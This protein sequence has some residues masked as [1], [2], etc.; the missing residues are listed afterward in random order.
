MINSKLIKTA[1]F[2]D[3][4]DEWN[5]DEG[6]FIINRKSYKIV[7]MNQVHG[8]KIVKLPTFTNGYKCDGLYT[9]K[10]GKILCV[11][12]ADCVPLLIDN[13][14]G[15]GAIHAGWKGLEKGILKKFFENKKYYTDNLKVVIGPHAKS[16]CYEVTSEMNSIFPNHVRQI[17]SKYVLDMTTYIKDYL[18]KFSI[19]YEDC[20]VCTIC[21]DNY[22][23]YRRNETQNRQF[24][25]V[26][27]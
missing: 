5:P 20:A 25:F 1:F 21:N 24:S 26:C 22:F 23:S 27:L 8:N 14:K 19:E 7:T 6:P 16:C 3:Q 13:G 9:E 4:Y 17:N 15:V 10:T 12:T 2:T 11:K 18:D